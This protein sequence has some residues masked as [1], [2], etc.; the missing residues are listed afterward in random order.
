MHASSYDE[1]KPLYPETDASGVGI[2]AIL[3]LIRNPQAV[4]ETWHQTTYSEALHW[5]AK[6]YPVQRRDTTIYREKH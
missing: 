6:V 4:Q 2:G 5:Q 1:T 3:L